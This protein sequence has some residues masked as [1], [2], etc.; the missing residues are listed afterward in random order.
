MSRDEAAAAM[1]MTR[2]APDGCAALESA[3]LQQP[4]AV[5]ATASWHR[6]LPVLVPIAC[7]CFLVLCRPVLSS[8]LEWDEAEQAL[9]SQ[10]LAWGYSHQP[11]LYT[12]LTW[13][14]TQ[15]LGV[16]LLALT[17]VKATVF[18]GLL[19]VLGQCLRRLGTSPAL[20]V[21]G[22]LAILISPIFA[23]SIF[24][25]THTLLVCLAFAATLLQAL[26]LLERPTTF[27]YLLLGALVGLGMLA[28]YN[29]V[30]YA[31]ALFIAALFTPAARSVLTN[32]RLTL[33]VLA[34]GVVFLPHGL[35]LLAWRDVVMIGL[36]QSVGLDPWATS[37]A[38]PR[39][40]WEMIS[41]LGLGIGPFVLGYW[42]LVPRGN[43]RWLLP[44]P[45]DEQRETRGLAPELTIIE[46]TA[47]VAAM[48]LTGAALIGIASVRMHW[49]APGLLL[50]PLV[51][52]GRLVQHGAQPPWKRW[53]G[54]ACAM[55]VVVVA[56]R[57][58]TLDRP[59]GQR[60]RDIY[61]AAACETLRERG[62]EHSHVAALDMLTAGNLRY[63]L[64]SLRVECMQSPAARLE[65]PPRP[66]PR[67][68]VWNA[69]EIEDD[70][71]Y[72]IVASSFARAKLPVETVRART[73]HV[74]VTTDSERFRVLAM[75]ED[76]PPRRWK[77]AVPPLPQSP[78]DIQFRIQLHEKYFASKKGSKE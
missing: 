55:I 50:A 76:V 15:A 61:F 7:G 48:V 32:R 56:V 41:S 38:P 4:V 69:S 59:G 51:L 72:M 6:L 75:F 16:N 1:C 5:A 65:P 40:G 70:M 60:D 3:A 18:A 28:K 43:R 29:Y 12:W 9:F 25:Y 47:L 46:R 78:A 68:V 17:L 26:R 14:T 2:R 52:F 19:Y 62:L 34:A 23:W 30:L 53:A 77:H 67:L 58:F 66:E 45:R 11:P 27:N 73:E 33:T 74:L 57:L 21:A 20:A 63:G 24:A 22:S 49:L 71:P 39:A 8:S 37:A 44:K 42:L 35:W 36:Q 64:P 13:A 31:G 10:R 54:A